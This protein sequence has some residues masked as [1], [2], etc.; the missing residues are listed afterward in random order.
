LGV[1]TSPRD[2]RFQ[3][4]AKS[5]VTVEGAWGVAVAGA[6]VVVVVLATV[7]VVVVAA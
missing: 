6:V 1:D 7:L 3:P 5:R 4:F 2:T